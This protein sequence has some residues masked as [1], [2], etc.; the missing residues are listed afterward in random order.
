M[1]RRKTSQP[2][3]ETGALVV[4]RNW[5]ELAWTGKYQ[6][7][8]Q[9]RKKILKSL[10]P[11][12]RQ[13]ATLETLLGEARGVPGPV[14]EVACGMGFHLLELS[15]RGVPDL[16]GMEIDPELCLLTRDAARRFDL[17][18]GSLAGDACAIPLGDASCAAVFSHSFF[19]H[20]YDVDL[21]LR[22]QIRVLKPGGLLLIFDGN[23]LNP[24]TVADLLFFYPLRSRGRHGGFKWLF[25]K[26]KVYRN[27]YGY[28]PLGR[29]EDI[30]TPGWWRKRIRREPQ[31]QLVRSVTGGAYTHRHLPRWLQ[32]F[33]GSCVVVARKVGGQ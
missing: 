32:P 3:L 11:F 29:D 13:L 23:L 19:E 20:V 30:Q 5:E 12:R 17:S 24:K 27:L 1:D 21:A 8:L 16:L 22:E 33:V 2:A 7:M 14:L 10:A 15:A 18:A 6:R 26:G 9:R 4:S 28:L 31:L 25:A